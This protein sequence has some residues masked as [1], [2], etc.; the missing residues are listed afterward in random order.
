MS[1]ICEIT[2]KRPTTGNKVSH[3]N[4][5]TKRRFLPNMQSHRYWVANEN[6]FIK[7]K[8]STRAMRIVDK[9]GVEAVL[10]ELKANREI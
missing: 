9:V 6:R 3:A 2:K 7:L 5:K 1:K 8:L 10:A 4:N